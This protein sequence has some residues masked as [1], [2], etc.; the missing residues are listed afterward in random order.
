MSDDYTGNGTNCGLGMV[1]ETREEKEIE[2]QRKQITTLRQQVDEL[3]A[4]N[5]KNVNAAYLKGFNNGK[6][7]AESQ[8]SAYR[9]ALE[10]LRDCDWVITPHDRMD[11]VRDIARQA[12]AGDTKK[13]TSA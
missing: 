3:E 1:Y 4:A 13:D 8:L 7:G 9:E 12:L 10:R 5:E 11:A 6:E 2:R